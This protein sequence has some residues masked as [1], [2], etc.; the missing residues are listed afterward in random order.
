[1]RQ[2]TNEQSR[3]NRQGLGSNFKSGVN[4]DKIDENEVEYKTNYEVGDGASFTGQMKK[5]L[6]DENGAMIFIKHGKGVQIWPDGATYDGDWRDGMAEG[7]GTFN[8]ANGDV[9]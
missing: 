5:S 1:M 3:S 9:Y 6:M 4:I 8:H 2:N 7:V